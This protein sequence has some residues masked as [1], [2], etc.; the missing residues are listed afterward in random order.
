MFLTKD[1]FSHDVEQR[2]VLVE[3]RVL[4]RTKIFFVLFSEMYRC[5]HRRIQK[6]TDHGDGVD[7]LHFVRVSFSQSTRCLVICPNN[8][9][10]TVL[11]V[12]L[13]T[14]MV[15]PCSGSGLYVRA[16]IESLVVLIQILR[17]G[18]LRTE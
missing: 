10:R 5:L 6:S 17:Y 18:L 2:L 14:R 8:L 7:P 16:T 3:I 1:Q 13:A 11:F 15:S 12:D 9:E 4:G